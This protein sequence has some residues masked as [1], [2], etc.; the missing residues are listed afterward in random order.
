MGFMIK[1]LISFFKIYKKKDRQCSK[2]IVMIVNSTSIV[3]SISK[4]N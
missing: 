2:K 1:K 4:R 3:N